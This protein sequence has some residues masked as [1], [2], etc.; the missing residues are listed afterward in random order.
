MFVLTTE[1]CT[2]RMLRDVNN[3]VALSVNVGRFVQRKMEVTCRLPCCSCMQCVV[4]F[5]AND[6]THGCIDFSY[7]VSVVKMCDTMNTDC[8]CS[9]HLVH[10]CFLFYFSQFTFSL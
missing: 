2:E 8:L 7:F 6:H 9:R 10:W 4:L 5:I 1:L 3:L